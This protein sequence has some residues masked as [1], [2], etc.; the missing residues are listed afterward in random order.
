MCTSGMFLLFP[1]ELSIARLLLLH[2]VDNQRVNSPGV[3]NRPAR[4]AISA[5]VL[6]LQGRIVAN[7]EPIRE[8]RV[9]QMGF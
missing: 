3:A 8:G 2:A 5:F 4:L 7:I 1:D 9:I 6:T